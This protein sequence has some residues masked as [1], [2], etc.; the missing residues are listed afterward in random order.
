MIV[1][2]TELYGFKQIMTD[3]GKCAHYAPTEVQAGVAFGAIEECVE[4]AI[5]GEWRG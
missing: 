3:S 4:A 2:H 1:S 5:I